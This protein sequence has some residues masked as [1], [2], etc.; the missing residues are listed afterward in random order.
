[1]TKEELINIIELFTADTS[2]Y[3]ADLYLIYKI[4]GVF[5]YTQPPLEEKELKP[6]LLKDYI[7]VLKNM[8]LNKTDETDFEFIHL[9]K[10]EATDKHTI[11]H[12]SY[13]SIPAAAKIFNATNADVK[14]GME[15]EFKEK[16]SDIWGF[17]I[18]LGNSEKEITLFKKNYPINLIRKAS[19]YQLFFKNN[20]LQIFN[21][22][23]LKLS[24]KIDV[25]YI[26]NELIVLDKKEFENH[27]E[28][29]AAMEKEANKKIDT[30]I[31]SKI[32]EDVTKIYDLIKKK[33]TLK[34]ILNID[35]NN[36]IFKVEP[37][38]IATFAKKYKLDIELNEDKTKISITSKKAAEV[39]VKLLN[40]DY[41][42][43]ELTK[44]LYDSR[45][46]TKLS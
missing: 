45:G 18:K 8:F 31:D 30:I 23:L 15:E 46:K 25:V 26:N 13:G 7:N 6:K 28:Y 12:I 40:D 42:I 37:K 39:F 24:H 1:M 4:D 27:F 22:D 2:S 41:L 14:E 29:I 36:P 44:L 11:Y 9:N 34:K 19:T 16:L 35:Q 20:A 43:S 38:K 10:G 17:I 5:Y 32:V 33:S 21:N 3:G